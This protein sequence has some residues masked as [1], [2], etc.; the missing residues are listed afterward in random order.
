MNV[1]FFVLVLQSYVRRTFVLQTFF[2]QCCF[3]FLKLLA[4]SGARGLLVDSINISG[5]VSVS[6]CVGDQFC[7]SQPR[8]QAQFGHADF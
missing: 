8:I 2:D 3:C 4:F 1:F 5:S 7:V 6:V